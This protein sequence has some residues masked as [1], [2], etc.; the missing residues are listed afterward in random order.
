M[1]S[2]TLAGRFLG[3][4]I[5]AVMPGFSSHKNENLCKLYIFYICKL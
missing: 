3:W 5:L 1:K 2:P 4:K